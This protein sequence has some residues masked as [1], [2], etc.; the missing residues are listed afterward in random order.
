MN[1]LWNWHFASCIVVALWISYNLVKF[2][3]CVVD[4]A[5]PP[6]T[7]PPIYFCTNKY[8]VALFIACPE[9]L[10]V[11]L[12]GPPFWFVAPLN[13]C[14]Y[15]GAKLSWQNHQFIVPSYC[16][17]SIYDTVT[18]HNAVDLCNVIL[19]T[20]WSERVHQVIRWCCYM[21]LMWTVGCGNKLL[22]FF[23]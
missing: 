2:I 18:P 7:W 5:Y 12:F 23:W 22:T 14:M 17:E 4:G 20:E 1:S 6:I 10:N 19:L 9:K 13:V 8:I 3:Y 11:F 15:A 21:C 16:L